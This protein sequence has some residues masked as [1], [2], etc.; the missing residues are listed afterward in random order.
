M[1]AIQ[2]VS[3]VAAD[4]EQFCDVISA[5]EDIHAMFGLEFPNG[6]LKDNKRDMFEG[7]SRVSELDVEQC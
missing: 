3:I 7:Q 2:E 1:A 5:I 4:D 6:A